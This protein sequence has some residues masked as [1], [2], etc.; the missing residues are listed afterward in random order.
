VW[1][2]ML[3]SNENSVPIVLMCPGSIG[4]T[5]HGWG[6]LSGFRRFSSDEATAQLII[7]NA[8]TFT[9][10]L[11][12]PVNGVQQIQQITKFPQVLNSSTAETG[13]PGVTIGEF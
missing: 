1:I 5:E 13:T 11:G 4:S 10:H 8:F 7:R 2:M 3:S 6:L 9:P 12:S